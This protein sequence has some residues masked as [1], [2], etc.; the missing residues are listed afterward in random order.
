M[1]GRGSFGSVGAA[2]RFTSVLL[3]VIALSLSFLVIIQGLFSPFHVVVSDS[4]APEIQTGDVV[5]MGEVNARAVNVGEVIVFLDPVDKEDYIIH[6]VIGMEKIGKTPVYITKGDNNTV[7]DP[8]KVAP[9]LIVG[10]MS[11]SVPKIGHFL[12]FL[13]SAPGYVVCVIIPAALSFIFAFGLALMEKICDSFSR[14]KRR[15]AEA[16]PQYVVQ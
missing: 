4:M 16:S 12:K 8:E 9:G 1:G 15:F 2:L 13:S 11:Y 6:R 7:A 10:S 14:R 3:I 5:M